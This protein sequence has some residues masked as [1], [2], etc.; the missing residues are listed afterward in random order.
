MKQCS[1][2]TLNILYEKEHIQW[3]WK[4]VFIKKSNGCENK[5]PSRFLKKVSDSDCPFASLF[6]IFGSWKHDRGASVVAGYTLTL[7]E[8]DFN[9]DVIFS[10]I[11]HIRV[12]YE[13]IKCERKAVHLL[14][15]NLMCTTQLKKGW[16]FFLKEFMNHNKNQWD[17]SGIDQC[18]DATG[19]L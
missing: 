19:F 14:F 2:N 18:K 7:D 6:I 4:A 11:S 12:Q 17:E 1:W 13:N 8:T 3:T 16:L 9:M 10:S 15:E 5:R